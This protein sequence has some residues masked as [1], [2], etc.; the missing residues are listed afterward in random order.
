[1]AG[2]FAA[3]GKTTAVVLQDKLMDPDSIPG[4]ARSDS[5]HSSVIGRSMTGVP[6]HDTG[7]NPG[8]GAS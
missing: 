1:M 5:T 7:L 6:W 3:E 4:A 8:L 2:K